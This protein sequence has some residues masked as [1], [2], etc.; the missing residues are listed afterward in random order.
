M[1]WRFDV[2]VRISPSYNFMLKFMLLLPVFSLI[3]RPQFTENTRQTVCAC[4]L[5]NF[6]GMLAARQ[7][8]KQETKNVVW[9]VPNPHTT[10]TSQFSAI[11]CVF[12]WGRKFFLSSIS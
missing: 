3:I 12:E 4:Q 10:N 6:G 7:N 5:V 11:F 1:N 2:P 8:V 9:F